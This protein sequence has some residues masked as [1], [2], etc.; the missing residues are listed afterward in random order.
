MYNWFIERGRHM[1]RNP[2]RA[3][4]RKNTDVRDRII[5]LSITIVVFGGMVLTIILAMG[6]EG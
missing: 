4:K 6:L 5:E 1:E 3:L 2:P